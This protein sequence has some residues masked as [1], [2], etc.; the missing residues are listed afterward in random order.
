MIGHQL[1][2]DGDPSK[3]TWSFVLYE[4]TQGRN[5]LRVHADS[6]NQPFDINAGAKLQL[7]STAKLRTLVTYLD[8]VEDLHN[9]FAALPPR[10]LLKQAAAA[11]DPL[12][13]WAAGYMAHARDRG[14][15][16]MLDA[17]M[18]RHYSGSPGSFFTG[19]GVQSFGNFEDSENFQSPTVTEAF[20][21]S[22]NLAF[23]RLLQDITAYYGNA[24]GARKLP[25]IL[26][27][28]DDPEREAYLRRFADEDGRRFL[29]RF[30]KDFHGLNP[31]QALDQMVRRMRP[32]PKRLATVYMTLHPNARIAD[33]QSFLNAHLPRGAL[34]NNEL[35]DLYLSTVPN[36]MGLVDRAYLA[37]IHPLELWLLEYLQKHPDASFDEVMQASQDARQEVYSWLFKG[38]LQK[39]DLRIRILMEQDAFEQILNN[40]RE[41]GY[42][43]HRLIPSLG[44]AIG[45][46]GDR[47]DALAKLMGIILNDG[48]RQPTVNI[49]HLEFG[50]G[51]P[52]ETSMAVAEKPVR[53][54]SP[55]V[56][57][58]LRRVMTNVVNEG[59]AG[60]LRGTYTGPD[61]QPLVVGGKTGTG[62]NR[63]DH[64]SAGGGITS[65]RVVD[66][67]ATFVFYLGDRFYG[68]V[69]AY[70]PG[71]PAA[72]FH[73]T[74][75]LAVQLLKSL[76]PELKPLLDSP[77]PEEAAPPQAEPLIAT[78][79][80]DDDAGSA[81]VEMVG[82]SQ[83]PQQVANEA[84]SWSDAPRSPS[85]T[86]KP[87]EGSDGHRARSHHSSRPR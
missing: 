56:A 78:A 46:S 64:F 4:H 10:E 43:F 23:I 53:V 81:D 11:Q 62:D 3:V 82:S 39:Q 50:K 2:G 68:T 40:W 51:T 38:S 67:T 73:F 69:T 66:R 54:M 57:R 44:T 14:L 79:A 6:L 15:Q 52:Y 72:R 34:D 26:S 7:G 42:P 12:T 9:R 28:P 8:I 35:W 61:G 24:G 55:E 49:E 84:G 60:R 31:Q 47:P 18:E 33:L 16:P 41:V 74:S 58:T 75:A 21:H 83:P 77:P 86:A 87:E 63:Y 20:A 70:V 17:A 32:A 37:G 71:A 1:L 59:T 13:A 76:Q 25:E 80:G 48:V 65:S 22:V 36:K 27:N 45:A 19:G 85:L 5:L 30:Y 29:T